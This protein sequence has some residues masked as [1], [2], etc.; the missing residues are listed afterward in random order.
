MEPEQ[1][2]PPVLTSEFSPQSTSQLLFITEGRLARWNPVSNV[3]SLLS[4]QVVEYTAS[5][6]GETIAVLRS[7]EV[8]GSDLQGFNLMMIDVTRDE[9]TTLVEQSERLYNLSVSRDGRWIAYTTQADGGSIYV[10]RTQVNSQVE[11]L[12]VCENELELAC[13]GIITWSPDSAHI[14]WSDAN[15]IWLSDLEADSARIVMPNQVEVKDPKG[16]T[17]EVRVS[18]SQLQWSPVGRY[19][20]ARVSPSASQVE[21][22]AIIDTQLEKLAELPGTYRLDQEAASVGWLQDGNLFI[23]YPS[24]LAEGQ[25]L[26]LERWQVLPTRE[27]LLGLVNTY[28]LTP[29][30]FPDLL[31]FNEKN[32]D[33]SIRWPFA[34]NDRII[35]FEAIRHSPAISPTLFTFDLKYGILSKI[36]VTPTDTVQVL[37]A[38]D[39]VGAFVLDEQGEAFFAP[40][41]ND[42]LV[43]LSPLIGD[44]AH[45]FVWLAPLRPGR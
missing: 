9:K 5:A 40:A 38:P 37:W 32:V 42:T 4:T 2:E 17:S 45:A 22:Q 3:M 13:K 28:R 16:E 14:A 24:D 36:N 10:M 11:K 29:Q 25:P 26:M 41:N 15:G 18:F 8:E 1:T 43:N 31:P 7:R 44:D 6:N 23:A 27:D 33:T 30:D 19:L 21:W 39:L 34:L 12:G 20:M 35:A